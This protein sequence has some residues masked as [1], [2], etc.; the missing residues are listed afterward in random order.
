MAIT[1]NIMAATATITAAADHRPGRAR[2][3]A[4]LLAGVA[5]LLLTTQATHR[6]V[7]AVIALPASPVLWEAYAGKPVPLPDLLAAAD[8]LR[9]A[10]DWG[11]VA[12]AGDRGYLLL[13]AASIAPLADQ[14]ALLMAAE[15]ATLSSLAQAP[16]NPS[17]WLRLASLR[18]RRGDGDGALAAWRMSVMTGGFEPALMP[19]RLSM[20]ARLL[21]RMD[22]DTRSLLVRQIRSTWTLTWQYPEAVRGLPGMSALVDQ[23][24]DNLT[25]REMTDYRRNNGGP[26]PP[27]PPRP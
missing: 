12:A 27:R 20:G 17:L 1:D 25:E 3:T 16:G 6:L 15:Q 8:N 13:R 18:E 24:L 22:A 14:F 21:P 19:D 7:A 9:E 10:A 23:A 11:S 5:G 26:P 4:L 2:W